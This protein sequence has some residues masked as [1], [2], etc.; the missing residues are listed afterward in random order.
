MNKEKETIKVDPKYEYIL[1]K[2][3]PLNE[4]IQR[5][6]KEN[7]DKEIDLEFISKVIS[8]YD[9]FENTEEDNEIND[10]DSTDEGVMGDMDL[11]L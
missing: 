9:L 6:M 10:V 3:L 4:T 7:H 5:F 8:E 11:D 1:K 2:E